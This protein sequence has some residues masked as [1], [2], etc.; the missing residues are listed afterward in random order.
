MSEHPDI[1]D[2]VARYFDGSITKEEFTRLQS[3][4]HSDPKALNL[5]MDYSI[6]SHLLTEMHQAPVLMHHRLDIHPGRNVGKV[7]KRSVLAAAACL[8]LLLTGLWVYTTREPEFRASL[9]FREQSIWF[10]ESQ[11]GGRD[12]GSR[13]QLAVG[14]VLHLEE[15]VLRASLPSRVLA[16]IEGP[17]VIRL[18]DDNT[19]RLNQG[20][21]WFSV[22]ESAKGFTVIAG[23]HRIVDLGTQFGVLEQSGPGPTEVHVFRGRVAVNDQDGSPVQDLQAGQALVLEA[24]GEIRKMAAAPDEFLDDLP[25]EVEIL[26][27]DDF[28]EGLGDGDRIA[29]RPPAGW[30]RVGDHSGVVGSFNPDPRDQWYSLPDFLDTLPSGGATN[31]MKGPSLAYIYKATPGTGM[32]HEV[33]KISPDSSYSLS[34]GI[35]HRPT[36]G[37]SGER[38]RFGGYTVSLLSGTTVLNSITSDVPPG[39]PDSVDYAHLHW[40]SSKLPQHVRVGDPIILR[41]AIN[42]GDYLDID[43]VRLVRVSSRSSGR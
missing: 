37:P 14:R 31:A 8:A 35:G 22:P 36:P 5:Y 24:A 43:N 40:N 34:F 20:R 19:L 12:P 3:C 9:R 33:G 21:G 13:E 42:H 38:V 17:A 26:F 15:G 28:E 6:D 23:R 7:M 29:T 11:D 41:I 16:V 25:L 27:A 18:E 1:V 10:Y 39:E 4:L 30:T 32:I 2:L